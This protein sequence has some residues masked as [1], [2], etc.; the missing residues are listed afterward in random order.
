MTHRVLNGLSTLVVTAIVLFGIA[1]TAAHFIQPPYNDR[2]DEHPVIVKIHVIFGIFYLVAGAFQFSPWLRRRFIQYHRA[3]GRLLAAAALV[4][5]ASAIFI[6]LV[7]PFS[8]R[9]EQ[10]IITVFGAYY[11]F[12]IVAAI[13]CIRTGQI[14]AHREWMIR[15]YAIGSSIVTMRLIFIPLLIATGAPSREM[16]ADLSIASFTL[17]FVLHAALAEWW[18]SYTRGVTAGA[19][20]AASK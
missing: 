16:V 3:A 1:F 2:F 20:G 10:M 9:A 17:A 15:A 18:L 12:S 6:G 5:G 7:I 19:G 4:I 13:I 8:G 14:D 11:L